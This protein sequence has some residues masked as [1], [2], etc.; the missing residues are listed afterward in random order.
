MRTLEYSISNSESFPEKK[1]ERVKYRFKIIVLGDPEVGKTSLV[2]RY[3]KNAFKRSYFPT[4][5]VNISEKTMRAY[6]SIV[7]FIVWDIAGQ[8]KFQITRRP[9]YKGAQGVLLV[10][11]QTN[12]ESFYNLSNWYQDILRE[13]DEDRDL[14]MCGLILGNKSDLV[15]ERK[16]SKE[17]AIKFAKELNFGYIE[18]SALT[19]E[20]VEQSF[21]TIAETLLKALKE[22]VRMP[23]V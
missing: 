11:D 1:E 15:D 5:G 19:G 4:I 16:I 20:N 17:S 21:K 18:T 7:Q 14:Q 2:L 22:R 12:L 8:T 23:K 6:N 9:F 3:T 13:R 10:F